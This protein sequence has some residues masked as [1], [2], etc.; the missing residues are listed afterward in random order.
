MVQEKTTNGNKKWWMLGTLALAVSMIVIDGTIVNVALPS[1]MKNLHFT[2]TNA[3]WMIT[4]YSLVF[5]SLL[6]TTGRIADAIGR[7]K[8][9]IAGVIVFII[10]SMMASFATNIGFM[11]CARFIQG[12]GGAMVL[13]T[14]LSTVN[15]FFKGKDR[16]IAFA[17]WGSVISGMAAVGPLLGGV[18]TTFATWH[19]VFWINLPLGIII[20]LG[21]LRFI[22]ESTGKKF[23]GHFD[24]LGFILSVIGFASVVYALIESK[25]YGWW[26]PKTGA[27][28]IAGISVIPYFLALGVITLALFVLWERRLEKQGKDPLVSFS[29]FGLRSFSLGNIIAI[30]VAVGEFGLLFVLP[31]FLQNIL[32]LSAMNAGLLLSLMGVGAFFAGGMATPFVKKTS[33]KV[34]VSTGLALE[35]LSLFLFFFFIQ[36]GC[37]TWLIGLFILIYGVGL[38]FASAQLT[39]IVMC[40][41]PNEKAGQG[42][43][44]Q[45][46][47]R[48]LGS[49]LG[50]AVVGT[51]FATFLWHD[52]PGSLQ[53]LNL[54]PQAE[55]GIETSVI[56]SAGASINVLKH[57]KELDLVPKE[58]RNKAFTQLD[59]QF[60]KSIDKCVGISG[61]ILFLSF[62]L[63]FFLPKENK[64]KEDE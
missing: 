22:P 17:V 25:N 31:L 12:V 45:S 33:P 38:G 56:E 3:E 29:L 26:T 27:P 14:T 18:F 6:I 34:V 5:S 28:T 13:P 59:A 58:N 24:W 4:I 53:P 30:V 37:S 52:I 11:L 60:T 54:P 19:W 23:S 35:A 20:I 63:T 49:A 39:S 64:K 55:Q 47:V 32:Q 62:I 16:V 1:I 7:K 8:M 9:L 43:A 15:Q 48:Q 42:S 50:I 57:N 10:S 2:F 61:C 44:I 46:T 40:E 51:M 21:A 41:I 36:P